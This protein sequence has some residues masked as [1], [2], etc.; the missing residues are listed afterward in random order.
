MLL[1]LNQKMSIVEWESLLKEL[2]ISDYDLDKRFALEQ[3]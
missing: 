1:L 3:L 2:D